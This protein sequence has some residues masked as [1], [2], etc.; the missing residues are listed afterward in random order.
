MYAVSPTDALAQVVAIP[1]QMPSGTAELLPTTKHVL[2]TPT[3]SGAWH[4]GSVGGCK[5]LTKARLPQDVRVEAGAPAE[6]VVEVTIEG[7]TLDWTV[8]MVDKRPT[9]LAESVFFSFDPAV[10]EPEGWTLQVLGSQMLSC[11]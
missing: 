5:I 9:R 4:S 11:H 1:G 6:V 8:V 2:M 3:M 10:A 7:S